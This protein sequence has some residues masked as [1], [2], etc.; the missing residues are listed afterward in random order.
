MT[1]QLSHE[2]QLLVAQWMRDSGD[3][4]IRDLVDLIEK[5]WKFADDAR[6][7]RALHAHQAEFPDHHPGQDRR[8]DWCCD[9]D[10][11]DRGLGPHCYWPNPTICEEC[12]EDVMVPA[13]VRDRDLC[14]T[15]AAE[16]VA[17]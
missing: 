3:Y 1:E 8:G 7:V 17:S 16:A 12:T 11:W 4:E 5:P 10:P 9:V 2:D 6:M 15:C 14:A 13:V